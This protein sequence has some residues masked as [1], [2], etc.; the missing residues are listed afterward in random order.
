MSIHSP[1][2][3][4]TVL[5]AN[6][7]STFRAALVG[8]LL[9]LTVAG[10]R[11][12]LA[13]STAGRPS[14]PTSARRASDVDDS[15]RAI[16]APH[17]PFPSEVASASATRF[18]FISYGDSRGRFDGELEQQLHLLVI[19]SMVRTIAARASGP[20]PIRFVVSSGDAVVDG[21][22]AQQW[23]V[24]FV[25][26][27]DRLTTAGDVPIFPAPG[28][29]DA[30]ATHAMDHD[31]P[32]RGQALGHFFAAFRNMLPPPSSPRRLAGFATYAIGYGN[33]FLI[34]MDSNIADDSTQ[35]AWVRAQLAGLDRQRYQHVAVVLHHPPFSSGPHGGAI[36]EPQAAALRARYM[37]L[38]RQYHVALVLA[39]HE[40]LF[41]HWVER[42]HDASGLH[43][44]DEIVTGGGGAPPYGYRGE[45]DLRD[46]LRAAAADSVTLEHL[47]R[48][49]LN[50]WETPYHYVVV[51]VNGD[52]LR[53]EVIGVDDGVDFQPYR[54]RTT[55]LD[56]VRK[57]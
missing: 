6:R 26:V 19:T 57:P 3:S 10:T 7:P 18:S 8:S 51:H 14:T 11:C 20:D 39:G 5:H 34:M 43:R 40:H 4:A 23:N 41:E 31:A 27:V 33:V 47:V 15:V 28:N 53:V 52:R 2:P 24:S 44:L 45:P 48:P 22:N 38:F 35:Y 54:S 49:A 55:D 56:P 17:T 36:V 25:P 1:S 46:Y 9:L 12:A 16:V 29:H 21:R 50:P 13:Q 30:N 37:P 42:Y 32:G